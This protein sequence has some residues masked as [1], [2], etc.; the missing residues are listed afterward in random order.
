MEHSTTRATKVGPIDK[1]STSP[2]EAKVGIAPEFTHIGIRGTGA[3]PWRPQARPDTREP[4]DKVGGLRRWG[5]DGRLC[6]CLCWFPALVPACVG[7]P[8]IVSLC[9]TAGA[10]GSKE[11][12]H[13]AIEGRHTLAT[14]LAML[15]PA[16]R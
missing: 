1:Q 9:N 3:T 16:G 5:D 4:A 11:K 6:L 13:L 14:T 8:T 7:L 12:H 10:Q 2:T 15:Q